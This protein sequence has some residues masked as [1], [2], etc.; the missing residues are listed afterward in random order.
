TGRADALRALG[1]RLSAAD[2]VVGAGVTPALGA[3]L[4]ATADLLAGKSDD[5]AAAVDRLDQ[6]VEDLTREIPWQEVRGDLMLTAAMLAANAG[7]PAQ[8]Q[9]ALR[10][11]ERH[12][13]RFPSIWATAVLRRSSGV[14][15]ARQGHL[16]RARELVE[17]ALGTL[18]LAGDQGGAIHARLVL[19]Q[20]DAASGVPEAA[21]RVAQHR[22]ELE[23]L[24]F[25]LGPTGYLHGLAELGAS[26]A[27]APG[28]VPA[29]QP[30]S[31]LE[32]VVVPLQRLAV[33]GMSRTLIQRELVTVA[34]EQ[35]AGA[36][37]C[38]H[39]LD[40][41]GQ[42]TLLQQ[43]GPGGVPVTEW[44]ELS[45]GAGRRLRLGAGG[46][47]IGAG[48][49]ALLAVLAAVA[50]LALELASLRRA[51]AHQPPP[52][53]TL[54]ESEAPDLPGFISVSEPMRQLKSNLVRLAR[55]RSTVI[56]SGESGSG[57]EVVA[58]AIHDLSTR[59]GKPYVAFNC[60]AVPRDLF[61]GQL[62][63]YRKGAFTGAATDHP[64]VLRAADGGTVLLDEIGELP[65]ELQPKLLRF[66][67]NGEIL[68]LGERKPL[69]LDV[70]V[71]AASFRDLAQL[72]RERRF[73]E[74]L[75]YRLEVVPLH[76][77]PLRERPDD[78]VALARH[79]I[80]QLTPAEQESPVLAPDALVALHAHHWP[81]NVRELRNVIERS[82]AFEPLPAVLG[83]EQLRI[84]M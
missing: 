60:A 73:R 72:V 35:A 68:P 53:A 7:T 9:R 61:E 26:R 59:A 34:S 77:P 39:E 45:D 29:P 11:A 65:L 23:R 37:V 78:V 69:R 76:V 30:A 33:R 10:R 16:Q 40:S 70:R 8:A 32:K 20:I 4:I 50:E 27:P 18:T 1:E 17:S 79:F 31:A 13:E 42:A 84:A 28:G 49:R 54:H 63:G 43:A 83:A 2:S 12:F 56:I 47:G 19:A 25:D 81:G 58:R 41:A 3:L 48:W 22:E 64:G 82:L 6:Y 52:G 66:L 51:G 46:P 38:L 21:P 24:G 15:L 36:T 14:L 57:K 67:E 75:Y 62:F 74:D 44:V 80:R 5:V 71:I 55:S